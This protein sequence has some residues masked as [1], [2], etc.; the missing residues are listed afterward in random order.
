MNKLVSILIPAYNVGAYIRQCLDSIVGQTYQ[1][2]QVVVVDDGS[3]DDTLS[4]CQ[5]YAAKYSYIEVHSQANAG[6]ATAR[7]VLLSYAKG[8][9]V[10]F[11]DADDWIELDM[12]EYLLGIA[13]GKNADIVTCGRVVNDTKPSTAV[14]TQ[15]EWNQNK[16]IYEFLRH[17]KYN[18]SLC[19]KLIKMSL[20]HNVRFHCGISYGEDAL[21]MWQV[22]QNVNSVAITDK[23]LYHYRMN[24]NSLSHQS[25]SPEKKGTGHLVWQRISEDTGRGWKQYLDIAKARFAL[26]DMWGL[27]FASLSGYPYDEHIKTRQENVKRNLANIR[28]TKLDGYDRYITAFLLS[29]WYGFGRIIKL[30]KR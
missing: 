17:V 4:I 14:P 22:L 3:K 26:E 15:E 1:N 20:L 16:V 6:V 28:K 21:F 29:Y 11:V 7:N 30:I 27:Y 13:I 9:Y 19:N 8:D 24:D 23:Q 18:G 10:L 5:E 25:W 2:L 12:V